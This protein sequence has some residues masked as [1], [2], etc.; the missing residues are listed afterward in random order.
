MKIFILSLLVA[1]SCCGCK[2][3]QIVTMPTYQWETVYNADVPI[4]VNGQQI[5][6]SNKDRVWILTDRT[7][8]YII[9]DAKHK[10][11]R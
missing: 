1:L 5:D 10:F 3:K 6:R 4:I 8:G 9:Y 2:S 7:L 11:Y